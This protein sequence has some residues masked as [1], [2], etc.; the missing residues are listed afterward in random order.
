LH[1]PHH[2]F[3]VRNGK[4]LPGKKRLVEGS[5]RFSCQRLQIVATKLLCPAVF[6]AEA[7]GK[8]FS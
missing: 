6:V 2:T 3:G 7:K 4:V 5:Q 8:S 1:A